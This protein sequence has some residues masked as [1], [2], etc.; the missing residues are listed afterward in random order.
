MHAS[1]TLSVAETSVNY[2]V[3]LSFSTQISLSF[4]SNKCLH[5][6]DLMHDPINL[7]SDT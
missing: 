3:K 4:Y 2:M 6:T 1:T 7:E 5:A